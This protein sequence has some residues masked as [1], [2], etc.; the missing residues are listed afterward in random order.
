[1]TILDI[2][3]LV[4]YYKEYIELKKTD[5]Y[6]ELYKFD[7]FKN[8]QI[9]FSKSEDFIKDFKNTRSKAFNLLPRMIRDNLLIF[10]WE[11]YED[12][13]KIMLSKLFSEE[14]ELSQ[15]INIFEK[16]VY[17]ICENDE[18]RKNNA[19]AKFGFWTISFLLAV[20]DYNKYL[21]INPITPF[22]NFIDEFNLDKKLYKKWDNWTRYVNWLK[23]VN[24]ELVKELSKINPNISLL[25]IQDFIYCMFKWRKNDTSN[26]LLWNNLK[27][28][29]N[30]VVMDNIS[31]LL[32]SK[33]QIIL[34]WPPGTGKTYNIKTIIENHS[35]EIYN[36]L[37]KENRVEFITFHQSF[38]YEEFI[39][40]IK[41]NL[42]WVDWE[43]SYWIEDGIF[44]KIANKAWGINI[45]ANEIEN[46]NITSILEKF[47]EYMKEN[48][49]DKWED[50]PL[51]SKVTIEW[52]NENRWSYLLGWS[53]RST[54]RLAVNIIKRDIQKYIDWDINTYEDIKP[55][56][57][58]EREFHWNARYYFMFYK[59]LEEFIKSNNYKIEKINES[60]LKPKNYYLVIDEINRWNISKIFGELITLL[61]TDKRIWKENE[62]ITKLP[63]SKEDFW[64]PSNIYIVATMNTSDKSIVSLDTAL[65]RRF[66]FVEMLTDYNLIPEDIDW[67][68]LRKILE[69]LN[70]RI[71]YLIDKDHIIWH[72][73]FINKNSLEDIVSVFYNEI[74]PLLEEYFYWEEDK[75]K[76]VLWK[77]FY[78][79][80]D[81]NTWN[82]FEQWANIYY[83]N[84]NLELL[85]QDEMRANAVNILN[86]IMNSS[87]W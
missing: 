66:G 3:K 61:E 13:F 65:R 52:I 84:K 81:T 64:I 26:E 30:E 28:K 50:F 12:D 59:K 63:Y 37:E 14:K 87:Q 35:W 25:E 11:Y 1:M 72:S 82:I 15:R 2:Q 60:N 7:F 19:L 16:Q 67:V 79:N 48:F 21:F 56:F 43:I 77:A 71:E 44:K 53:I 10:F 46:N 29:T 47:N 58:S 78:K 27:N 6:D 17:D 33:K 75:I 23:F 83:E 24:N 8:N 41:P 9:D 20:K 55:A 22:N 73:Y 36:D 80:N 57:D 5:N 62:V 86:S 85:T 49:L 31:N 34:Y 18:R 4:R 42:D 38:S 39:E 40:G 76:L 69:V 51:L 54:Q 68:K 74:L 70:S 32:N 45:N